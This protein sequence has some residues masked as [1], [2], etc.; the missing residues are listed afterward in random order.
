MFQR[1]HYL[2]YC[3]PR[4][5]NFVVDI[6]VEHWLYHLLVYMVTL[7]P[8]GSSAGAFAVALV[9]VLNFNRVLA[10]LITSWTSLEISPAAIVRL[11]SL[12][13]EPTAETQLNLSR[14]LPAG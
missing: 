2:L 10:K 1:P 6:Y 8:N 11:K 12:E 3:N 9:S 7:V 4:W 13:I 14:E 5:L